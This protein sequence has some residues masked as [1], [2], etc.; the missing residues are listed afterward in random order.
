MLIAFRRLRWLPIGRPAGALAGA[1]L[2]VGVGALDPDRAWAA[3]D[4]GT[5]SLLLGMML[6]TAYLQRQRWFAWTGH[7]V[8]QWARTPFGLLLA[9]SWS[10][11]A[12]SAVLV[13]DTV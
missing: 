10:A 8:L 6:V 3:I 11:A 5:L 12:L 4:G 7:R 1:V 13:N 2:M 9:V